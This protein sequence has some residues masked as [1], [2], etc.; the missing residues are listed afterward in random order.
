MDVYSEVI[1]GTDGS[2]AA[3]QAVR[4]AASIA[5]ALDV[6]LAIV[7]AW[8]ESGPDAYLAASTLTQTAEVVAREAGATQVRRLEPASSGAAVDQL[9]TLVEASAESLLVVGDRGVSARG[10]RFGG[11]TAHQLTHHSPV[12]V[13]IAVAGRSPELRRIAT[14]TD[15]STTATRGVYKGIALARALGVVPDVLTVARSEDEG[16][17]AV[18]SV[19]EDLERRGIEHGVQVFAA[20]GVAE[21]ARTLIEAAGDYDLLVIG[22]RGMSGPARL[23]GSVS[24]RISHEL[25]TNLLVVRTVV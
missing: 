23:L 7:S 15:G 10:D 20:S 17:A 18:A 19:A 9:M 6:E 14:T 5:A 24:N 11:N 2:E 12:D 4:T 16:R 8:T 25:T 22:N 1:A 13:L 3:D 21:T